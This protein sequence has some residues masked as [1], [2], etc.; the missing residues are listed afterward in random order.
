MGRDDRGWAMIWE[1]IET[2]EGRG[3]VLVSRPTV[4]EIFTPTA[5]F[6]DVT[7]VWR[8]FRSEGGNWPLSF[9]PTFWMPLP[10]P[11]ETAND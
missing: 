7:G 9:Q 4:R 1:P 3:P 10:K 2:Y 11:P 5:A 6:L 8:V